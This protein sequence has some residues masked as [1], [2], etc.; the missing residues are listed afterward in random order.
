[1]KD[2]IY[3]D[4]DSIAEYCKQASGMELPAELLK[5]ESDDV[6]RLPDAKI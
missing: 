2:C 6:K 1:M 3:G 5:D 4:Y